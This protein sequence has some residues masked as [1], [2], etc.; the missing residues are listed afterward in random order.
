MRKP[1]TIVIPALIAL[2]ILTS[3]WQTAQAQAKVA[4]TGWNYAAQTETLTLTF[5]FPSQA[6][7]TLQLA[8]GAR[9]RESHS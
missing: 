9:R 7:K 5:T 1:L 6:V 3:P 4:Y 2:A 8:G